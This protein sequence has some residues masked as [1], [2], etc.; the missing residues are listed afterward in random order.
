MYVLNE[1]EIS[2]SERM[3]LSCI[4]VMP[5]ESLSFE[6]LQLLSGYINDF[7]GALNRLFQLGWIEFNKERASCKMSPVVQE[8]ILNKNKG[9]LWFDCMGLLNKLTE[10][11]KDDKIHEENFKDCQKARFYYF[12]AEQLL[13]KWVDLV[14]QIKKISNK[15]TGV[16]N[17][18]ASL[19]C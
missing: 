13:K 1:D 19:D 5:P 15:L 12:N 10:D 6:Y 17:R 4:T 11:L 2:I 18:I 9:N 3:V 16:E 7:E 14:P 8:V